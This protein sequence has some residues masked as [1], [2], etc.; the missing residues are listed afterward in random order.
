MTIQRNKC[1]ISVIRDRDFVM[2][3]FLRD[4][5]NAPM[6][7]TGWSGRAQIRSS[8]S[9][10]SDLLVDLI[11][12]VI[13]A[14]LGKIEVYGEKADTKICAK[15]GSWDLVLMNAEGREDS[16]LIGDVDFQDAPTQ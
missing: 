9:P 16:Y 12:S 4:I 1:D 3:A 2:H 8:T 7:L 13:D 14:A 5:N 6:D 11:V 10:E 15:T